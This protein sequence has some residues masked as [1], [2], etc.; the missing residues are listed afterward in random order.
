MPMSLIVDGIDEAVGSTPLVR[1]D[2]LFPDSGIEILAKLESVNPGGSTKDRP[3]RG[4][5][6]DALKTGRLTRGGT[7]VESSSGNL[8][9]ALARACNAHD[10]RFV[11]VV[12]ARTNATTVRLITALGGE[13]DVV[14]EP[15]PETGDLLTA[16]FHRVEE[17]LAEIPGAV[18]LYQYGNPANPRAHY[19][20]TMREIAEAT[21]HQ[22]DVLM[23]AVSTTGTIGGCAAYIRDHRMDTRVVAVDA[24]G[25]VLFGGTAA[26]R[27]LPGMGAGVVTELSTQVD[28]DQVIRM[29][30]LDCVV[31]ARHLA[32]S[33]GILAGASTGGVVSAL[34]DLIPDLAPGTRVVF[35]VHD[36]GVPYLETVYD[37]EWVRD[38]LDADAAAIAEGLDQ[39]RRTARRG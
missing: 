21:G 26:P 27:L 19:D 18:N 7:V 1:L 14:T 34:G 24:V 15:D 33:E 13:V 31:G 9:V 35:M 23:A 39:L 37:D 20:G 22:V 17:L 28:P 12:D 10:V 5:V 29:R 3:A 2:A 25:S 6:R 4:M 38:N 8:G 30:A 32:R 11:C 16:R 36:G